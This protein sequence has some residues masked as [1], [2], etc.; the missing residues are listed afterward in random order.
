MSALECLAVV[1]RRWPYSEHSLVV[2]LLT[3]ELGTVS[4][5]A[6][7]VHRL[8]SG[9]AG[10]LDTHALVKVR[11]R[12]HEDREMRTLTDVSLMDRFSGISRSV[13]SLNYA[14]LLAE[15]AELASPAEARSRGVFLQFVAALQTL[16]QGSQ[17]EAWL[18]RELIQAAQA[19]GVHP[20]FGPRDLDAPRWFCIS[21]GRLLEATESRPTGPATLL[22]PALHRTLR[23]LED[24]TQALPSAEDQTASDCLTM[25]G[26]FLGYHLERPPRAWQAIELRRTARVAR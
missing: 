11:L 17:S 26:Q 20:E 8:Q 22:T 6:K 25:L 5:L 10:V 12:G 15:L 7:G 1:L 23:R 24:R 14:A 21:T 2:H 4:A 3:P 19:L 9:K 13:D 18:A 16:D